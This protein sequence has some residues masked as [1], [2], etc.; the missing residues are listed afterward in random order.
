[1]S[2][3]NGSSSAIHY[4]RFVRKGP[5]GSGAAPGSPRVARMRQRH[6]VIFAKNRELFK[7]ARVLDI[8]SSSGFWSLA[9]LRSGA[10]HV[11]GIDAKQAR[12]E[13]A[14]QA[15]AE[16]GVASA[17]Y[18][19]IKTDISSSLRSLEPNAF[20]VVISHG[21]LEQSDPRFFFHQINRLKAKSVILDTAIVRGKGPIVRMKLKSSDNQE[22]KAASRYDSILSIPNHELVTF[23]CDYF[24][25]TC[26]L[27]DWKTMNIT[28]WSGINDYEQDHRRT[29]V[30]ERMARDEET[31]DE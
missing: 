20:D 3:T 23:F 31:L 2:L 13:A 7:G 22:P 6:D 28:D 18:Q 9:A 4:D 29:Y 10:V 5:T 24:Q 16:D 21:F 19:F 14:K 12:I 11:T 8:A 15:F 17:A 30:L 1:M 26:R 25:Y 27:I